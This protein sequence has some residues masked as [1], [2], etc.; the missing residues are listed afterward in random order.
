VQN[1]VSRN[2]GSVHKHMLAITVT[3]LGKSKIPKEEGE[4]TNLRRHQNS[5]TPS[6]ENQNQN[7]YNEITG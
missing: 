7:L 5:Q 6:H 2:V 1:K 4:K 3:K